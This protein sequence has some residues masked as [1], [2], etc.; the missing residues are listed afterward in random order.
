MS[1]YSQ[2]DCTLHLSR[3]YLWN[4][5]NFGAIHF[6]NEKRKII[7]IICTGI[8]C[9]IILYCASQN[10]CFFV[11]F[12]FTNWRFVATCIVQIYWHHFFNSIC[13][14]CVSVSCFWE[15][16]QYLKACKSKRLWPMEGS[17]DAYYFLEINYF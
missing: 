8:S 15:F 1:H 6:F 13:S 17:D 12:V 9:F 14:F 7:H 3:L 10:L 2:T 5:K 11:V 16:S 4:S